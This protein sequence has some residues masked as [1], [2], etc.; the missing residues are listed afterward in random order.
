MSN[1]VKNISAFIRRV[2]K[3]MKRLDQL[4]I[5]D[6][7]KVALGAIKIIFDKVYSDA[8]DKNSLIEQAF[9]NHFTVV[10][11]NEAVLTNR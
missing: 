3:A 6:D 2:P 5:S 10:R 11:P 1:K 7:D 9:H 8:H 4:V